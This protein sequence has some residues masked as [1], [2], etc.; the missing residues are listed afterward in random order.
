MAGMAL[1]DKLQ[2]RPLVCS[3]VSSHPKCVLRRLCSLSPAS[4]PVP[5]DWSLF[6]SLGLDSA[7]A[8]EQ[9]LVSLHMTHLLLPVLWQG[10]LA[11]QGTE[12]ALDGVGAAGSGEGFGPQ[13]EGSLR[14]RPF[15]QPSVTPC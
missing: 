7:P 3:C 8:P 6:L 9:L 12:A 1:I 14:D 4:W 15:R 5:L 11:I 13:V 2:E 10:L